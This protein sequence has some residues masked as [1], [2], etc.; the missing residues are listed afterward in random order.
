LI[1]GASFPECRHLDEQMLEQALLE[2]LRPG[3]LVVLRLHLV[4]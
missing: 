2:S 3:D 1:K 4:S